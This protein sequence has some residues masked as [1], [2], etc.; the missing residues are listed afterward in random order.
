MGRDRRKSNGNCSI[1]YATN[2]PG[3]RDAGF[4]EKQSEAIV[5]A[6]QESLGDNVATKSDLSELAT[7]VKVGLLELRADLYRALWIQGAGLVM[8]MVTLFT[9]FRAF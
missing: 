3:A 7:K 4:D 1:R 2:S 5:S 6:I 8:I 9:L